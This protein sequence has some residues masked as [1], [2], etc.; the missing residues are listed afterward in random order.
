MDDRPLSEPTGWSFERS[1]IKTARINLPD[2]SQHTRFS[3]VPG[4]GKHIF[5]Y[6]N[7]FI[8]VN[9]ERITKSF[10]TNGEPFES[11]TLTTL[12]AHRHVFEELFQEAHALSVQNMEGKTVVYTSKM[13]EWLQSGQPKRKRPFDSVVLEEG[14]S[15]K[16]LKDV[17]EFL[18]A[19]NWYLDRG[20]PYRRGYL[21][22]GP[23]GTGKT[24]F[25]QALAGELDF[26]IAML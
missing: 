2:G 19:R 5:R 26:S 25:V 10:D 7:A 23:P 11:V 6:K 13:A 3:L 21:L 12:Y 14:L 18:N 15:G 16:I 4:Q 9:R 20:I 24:S 1:C 17:R 8:A 22:F